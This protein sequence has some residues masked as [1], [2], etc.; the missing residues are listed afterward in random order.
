[1]RRLPT[2]V[3]ACALLF[4]G[5]ESRAQWRVVAEVP[6]GLETPTEIAMVENDSGHSLRI[7]RD[8]Q[9]VRG[10][11]AIRGGFDTVNE[12][13]CPTYRVDDRRPARLSYQKESCRIDGKRVHFTLG[14]PAAP[15]NG[16]LRQ[17]MNGS[18]IVIRYR[19]RAGHYRETEFT[20]LHSKYALGT[21]VGGPDL[22]FDE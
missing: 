2:F 15:R 17:L 10:V 7:Y 22:F 13:S 12:D 11:F 19:L 5:G 21:A 3:A 4:S 20:L 14:D 6:A 18:S 16:E 9:D 1:M 8:A